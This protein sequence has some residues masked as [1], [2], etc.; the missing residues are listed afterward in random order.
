MVAPT[1]EIQITNTYSA[2]EFARKTIAIGTRLSEGAKYNNIAPSIIKTRNKAKYPYCDKNSCT[3]IL[4]VET[5]AK[6]TFIL[7]TPLQRDSDKITSPFNIEWCL[8]LESSLTNMKKRKVITLAIED[9]LPSLQHVENIKVKL[10][11]R[12]YTVELQKIK[13]SDSSPSKNFTEHVKKQEK[14]IEHLN[15]KVLNSEVNGAVYPL[16]HFPKKFPKELILSGIT[17]QDVVRDVLLTPHGN[18]ITNLPHETI[19]GLFNHRNAKQLN[20]IQPKLEQEFL[21]EETPPQFENWFSNDQQNKALLLP[22]EQLKPEEF[23]KHT[24]TFFLPLKHFVPAP[25]QGTFSV[26]SLDETKLSTTI[27]NL[28]D[29]PRSRVETITERVVLSNLD[30]KLALSAGIHAIVKGENVRVMVQLFHDSPLKNINTHRDLPIRTYF[31]SAEKFAIDLDI[32][33]NES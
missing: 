7:A 4:E 30:S 24:K 14:F 8:L 21:F 27:H 17:R 12:N 3:K 2:G 25:C 9:S 23:S 29:N 13:K 5:M 15:Q 26:A 28:I 18:S 33:V 6:T 1:T 10:E 32:M 16:L 11:S 19:V 31:E 22:F 20:S